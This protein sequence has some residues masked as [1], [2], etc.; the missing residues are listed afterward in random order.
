ME[1]VVAQER[2]GILSLDEAI[3]SVARDAFNDVLPRFHTVSDRPLP[4]ASAIEEISCVVEEFKLMP[5]YNK[6]VRD[7]IPAIIEAAGERPRCRVLSREEWDLL[8]A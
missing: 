7:R 6:L 5:T 4:F 2:T 8:Y 3:A 1:R